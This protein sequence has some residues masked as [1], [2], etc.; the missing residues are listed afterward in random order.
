MSSILQ[1]NDLNNLP[2]VDSSDKALEVVTAKKVAANV[3]SPFVVNTSAGSR[4]SSGVVV[5]LGIGM[6]GLCR[7]KRCLRPR[8]TGAHYCLKREH[9]PFA[10]ASSTSVLNS[11]GPIPSGV[12]I[13]RGKCFADIDLISA[14]TCARDGCIGS[15]ETNGKYCVAGTCPSN[16]TDPKHLG[17]TNVDLALNTSCLFKSH[18]AA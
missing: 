6:A 1:P 16:V 10:W 4:T 15:P 18:H 12:L 9:W 7:C 2:L 17:P 8:L 3:D 13:I 11:N 5:S 14:E